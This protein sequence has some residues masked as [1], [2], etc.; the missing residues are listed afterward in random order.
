[1]VLNIPDFAE[2]RRHTNVVK[3][4]DLD[5][6]D[7]VTFSCVNCEVKAIQEEIR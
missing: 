5:K 3:M 2:N 4:S 1:M 6:F 7:L